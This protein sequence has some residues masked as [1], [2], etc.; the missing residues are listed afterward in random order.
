MHESKITI[1]KP[2]V[3]ITTKDLEEIEPLRQVQQAIKWW[4]EKQKKAQGKDKYIIKKAIIE[5]RKDQYTIKNAYRKPIVFAKK[6]HS[7]HLSQFDDSYKIDEEGKVIP[8]GISFL[9]PKVISAILCNYSRLKQVGFDDLES[10]TW[11]MML[12][13]DI[14]AAKALEDYPL[15][16]RIALDKIDGMQN[17]DIQKDIEEQYNVKYSLEYISSLWRKKIPNLIASQAEDDLLNWHYL[18]K[19]KGKYKKCSKC[20]RIKLAHNKYFSR[21]KTSRDGWY[22]ICKEC[23]NKHRKMEV[24]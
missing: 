1:F 2:K 22:S 11:Y 7:K 20:G 24:S 6:M 13:F 4:E 9:N 14:L 19:E 5:L 15:Y 10:D 17:I 18:Y 3:T 21:N 12:D 16:D 8:E 23:R